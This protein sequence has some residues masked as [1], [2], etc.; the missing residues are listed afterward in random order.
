MSPLAEL[1][2]H[3]LLGLDYGLEPRVELLFGVSRRPI[4][5]TIGAHDPDAAPCVTDREYE[6]L[7]T[8][9]LTD[10][11]CVKDDLYPRRNGEQ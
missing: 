9:I 5:S 6:E 3:A 11:R 7:D 2:Y 8:T 4:C 1:Q 10:I